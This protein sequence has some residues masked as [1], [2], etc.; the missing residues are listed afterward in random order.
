MG[1]IKRLYKSTKT[2]HISE[3]LHS[4][5]KSLAKKENMPLNKFINKGIREFTNK[6]LKEDFF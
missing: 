6:K 1:E 2:V 3:T 5:C 4:L